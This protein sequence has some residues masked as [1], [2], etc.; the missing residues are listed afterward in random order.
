MRT[1][2]GVQGGY[3][4]SVNSDEVN[5]D[6][7]RNFLRS[8]NTDN[9]NWIVFYDTPKEFNL[10][11]V[12]PQDSIINSE[13]FTDF[14]NANAVYASYKGKSYSP[15]NPKLPMK[16]KKRRLMLSDHEGGLLKIKYLD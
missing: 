15:K 2:V 13:K 6:F 3:S 10:T 8:N 14:S 12:N 5:K 9:N 7:R 1:G 16:S 4:D 11:I